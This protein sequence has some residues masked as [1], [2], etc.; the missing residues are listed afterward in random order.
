MKSYV[1][2]TLVESNLIAAEALAATP[3]G[4]FAGSLDELGGAIT[5]YLFASG[6]E[7]TM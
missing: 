3:W 4:Q 1:K 5:S 6:I 2:P 7:I